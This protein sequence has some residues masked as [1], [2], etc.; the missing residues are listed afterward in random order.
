MKFSHDDT[1]LPFRRKRKSAEKKTVTLYDEIM[2]LENKGVGM[3]IIVI[4][5]NDGVSKMDLGLIK[6]YQHKTNMHIVDFDGDLQRLYLLNWKIRDLSG[7]KKK[8]IKIIRFFNH[9]IK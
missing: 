8:I 1:N 6:A 3:N 2:K 9:Y 7:L 4:Y 5:K